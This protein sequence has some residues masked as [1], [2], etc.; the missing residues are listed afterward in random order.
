MRTIRVS[1]THRKAELLSSYPSELND[2][3]KYRKV[4]W[5]WTPSGKA[6]IHNKAAG[7][8]DPVTGEIPGW[9][10]YIHLM[11]DGEMGAGVFLAKKDEIEKTLSVKFKIKDQRLPLAFGPEE[12]TDLDKEGRIYQL[13]CV[14]AMVNASMTGGLVLQ[15]TGSGKTYTTGKFFRRLKGNALFLVDELTLLK[16]AQDELGS[17]L[18]EDIGV[19]GNS[20]FDP[21][22]ITVGTIQTVH[23]HRRDKSYSSWTKSLKVIIIDEVH[24]AL[25]RRNFQTVRSINPPAIFGLTAT[26]ELK[27]KHIAMQAYDLCGPVIYQYPLS[28]G[29]EEGYLS[30]GVAVQVLCDSGK[31][32]PVRRG[33]KRFWFLNRMLGRKDYQKEY[34]EYIVESEKRNELI[35]SLVQA[36]HSRGKY[37][38]ILVERVKH[39][40]T[41]SAMF[42]GIPHLLLYGDK[43]V[44]ERV[45][46]K[47]LFEKGKVRVILTNKIFKKG[48]NIKRVDV[49]LDGAAMKSKNDAAQKYGRGVRLSD[50]KLGLIYLDIGDVGNR[51]EK[52][53]KSRISAIKKLGVPIYKVDPQI[54]ILKILDLAEKKLKVEVEKS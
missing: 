48:V 24:L 25:N 20:I 15:A 47:D 36:C 8:V 53:A 40:E 19:I 11:R 12:V 52:A 13:E 46:G 39:L 45:E 35:L 32:A 18:G 1:L 44:E 6:Y 26:L 5:D 16:Q 14:E 34:R 42:D 43:S 28:Q 7:I 27:K 51:F 17:V 9:D 54:G 22:R 50:E 4:G 30:R 29:V 49:I 37:I 2:I 23:L 33:N 10:G 31:P 38:I 41:L 21:K 3:L